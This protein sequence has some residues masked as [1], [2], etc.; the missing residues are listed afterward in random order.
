MISAKLNTHPVHGAIVRLSNYGQTFASM[1]VPVQRGEEPTE[2][3]ERALAE[4]GWHTTEAWQPTG[5]AWI[6]HV[7]MTADTPTT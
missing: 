2:A 6:T 7:A 1:P 4:H 5:T 3:A